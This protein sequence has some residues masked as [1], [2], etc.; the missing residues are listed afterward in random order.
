MNRCVCGYQIGEGYFTNCQACIS[1]NAQQPAARR[2]AKS[3]SVNGADLDDF[4]LQ[5]LRAQKRPHVSKGLPLSGVKLHNEAVK[6]QALA[7]HVRDAKEMTSADKTR[8]FLVTAAVPAA[9]AA[10]ANAAATAKQSTAKQ[11]ANRMLLL[12]GWRRCV[13]VESNFRTPNLE[14]DDYQA[15]HVARDGNCLFHCFIAILL[16]RGIV[17]FDDPKKYEDAKRK[18]QCMKTNVLTM[19]DIIVKA[20]AEKKNELK[21]LIFD[22]NG[23]CS[24]E[25]LPFSCQN[26][27]AMRSGRGGTEAYGGQSEIVAFAMLYGI[28]VTVHAPETQAGFYTVHPGDRDD[29][30][31]EEMLLY[32][33]GWRNEN[34]NPGTD[35]WQRVKYSAPVTETPREQPSSIVSAAPAT[36]TQRQENRAKFK[37]QATE[38]KERTDADAVAHAAAFIAGGGKFSF[39]EPTEAATHEEHHDNDGHEAEEVDDQLEQPEE[40]AKNRPG[41]TTHNEVVHEAEEVRPGHNEVLQDISQSRDKRKVTHWTHQT[42]IT[43]LRLIQRLNPWTQRDSGATWQQIAD[44]MHRDTAHLKETNA[45]GK[46]IS[47][48]VHSNGSALNMWYIRQLGIMEGAYSERKERTESGQTG[49]LQQ[50]INAR[51]SQTGENAD[52]IAQEWATLMALRSLQQDAAK[53][54]L[55][56]KE[57]SNAQ[58]TMKNDELPDAIVKLACEDEA[59][60]IQAIRLLE[61]KMKKY[62]EQEKTLASANRLPVMS[63]QQIEERQLLETLKAQRR[64]AKGGGDDSE[65]DEHVTSSDANRGRGKTNLKKSF[66][67]MSEKM[68]ELAQVM[69]EDVSEKAT[70]LQVLQQLLHGLDQDIQGGLKLEAEERSQL[71]MIYLRQYAKHQMH[72]SARSSD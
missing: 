57:K 54:A 6:R 60:Q 17:D 4:D 52:E 29:E 49:Q 9:A 56:K 46:E 19:R 53:A 26:L 51:A 2:A 30:F 47:C 32:T 68:A 8:E 13:A 65:E 67:M 33:L 38:A 1:H 40:G 18:A 63:P 48:Q 59:I 37:Q 58:K 23:V 42:R 34:R 35:H 22:S 44:T 7:E 61:K 41:H 64:T 14:H 31:E 50:C 28:A 69:K 21:C 71:R 72:S 10:P 62:A 5:P 12:S 55:M 66:D 16:E 3:R 39:E 45:R 15:V 70:T 25:P 27:L 20:F 43:C 11:E 24:E 36:A